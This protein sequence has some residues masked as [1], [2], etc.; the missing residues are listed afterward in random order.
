MPHKCTNCEEIYPDGSEEILSG[1]PN[2]GW[3]KFKY[4]A[5]RDKEK[6]IKEPGSGKKIKKESEEQKNKKKSLLERVG[7]SWE[8]SD[9]SEITLKELEEIEEI[10]SRIIEKDKELSEDDIES[11]RLKKD[12]SYEI[13][14]KSLLEQE[15]IIISIGEDGRY[16][17][18]L[19][20][21]LKD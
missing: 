6:T 19:E 5:K 17:I 15:G 20:S 2:C 7:I 3:N 14:L 21:F 1:C 12:G 11:F 18:D 4:L 13:N 9:E 8:G 10:G 16:I